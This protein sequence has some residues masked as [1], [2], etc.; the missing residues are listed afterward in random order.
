MESALQC[1]S[2]LDVRIKV[3]ND[4]IDTWLWRKSTHT[5]LLL[6]FNANCSKK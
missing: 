5:S 3:N 4:N 1:I 2:F 6:N